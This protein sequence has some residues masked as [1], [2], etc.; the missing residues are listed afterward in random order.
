MIEYVYSSK[1]RPISTLPS[2][3]GVDLWF[4][5]IVLDR[6][7]TKPLKAAD[8][9]RILSPLF[10][11]TKPRRHQ[12]CGGGMTVQLRRP[13][14]CCFC[15]FHWLWPGGPF[16]WFIVF[17]TLR[18]INFYLPTFQVHKLLRIQRPD[19]DVARSGWEF[20]AGIRHLHFVRCLFEGVKSIRLES[21]FGWFYLPFAPAAHVT[22]FYCLMPLPAG[23][24]HPK[25]MISKLQS[26]LQYRDHRVVFRGFWGWY[27]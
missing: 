4:P 6:T 26:I 13:R 21:Y 18:H 12:Q 19:W 3:W 17:R 22:L 20:N 9:R 10:S 1:F 24:N 2:A 27:K 14:G 7:T 23:N 11:I 15:L 25:M 16:A 8:T 5:D